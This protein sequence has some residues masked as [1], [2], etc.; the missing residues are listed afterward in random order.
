M[1]S[2]IFSVFTKPVVYISRVCGTNTLSITE[3]PAAFAYTFVL[4]IISLGQLISTPYVVVG[5]DNVYRNVTQ[6]E[7]KSGFFTTRRIIMLA[8]PVAIIITNISSKLISLFLLKKYLPIIYS[9]L[10]C[11]D[12]TMTP[13]ETLLRNYSLCS[14]VMVCVICFVVVPFKVYALIKV[15]V[16]EDLDYY[17]V[18]W[19]FLLYFGN[20]SSCSIEIQFA[21]LCYAV[22]LRFFKVTEELEI[23]V[24]ICDSFI[25]GQ[26][27]EY[28]SR[29]EKVDKPLLHKMRNVTTEYR[30]N[31]IYEDRSWMTFDIKNVSFEKKIV[32]YENLVNV[33]QHLGKTCNRKF[34]AMHPNFLSKIKTLHSVYRNLSSVLF[35]LD[36]LYQIQSLISIA[37][38]FFIILLDMYF[39]LFGFD[40]A[41][42]NR[43]QDANIF[44]MIECFLRFLVLIQAA[45]S[46]SA[47]VKLKRILPYF[48]R[49]H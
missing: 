35:D 30:N 36:A 3:H 42:I 24:N 23:L 31:N 37:A 17:I 41:K 47:E 48:F 20:L 14:G 25:L 34:R 10:K 6:D 22:K 38:M 9:N 18:I 28:L 12:S 15:A 45:H 26:V 13:S 29:K 46:T 32:L 2:E 5:I 39:A 40:G 8:F 33:S 19:F 44:W 4:L 11:A 7:D 49:D 43:H 21:T 16:D 1:E 27:D